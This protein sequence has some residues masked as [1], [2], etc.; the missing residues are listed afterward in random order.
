MRPIA[1]ILLLLATVAAQAQPE[2][3]AATTRAQVDSLLWESGLLR[4]LNAE[5]ARVEIEMLSGASELPGYL[6]GPVYDRIEVL[7]KP[8]QIHDRLTDFMVAHADTDSLARALA[9]VREPLVARV[10]RME[11]EANRA[12]WTDSTAWP[13]F[14]EAWAALAP[15]DRV[16]REALIGRFDDVTQSSVWVRSLEQIIAEA[17]IEGMVLG[18]GAEHEDF[19]ARMYAYRADLPLTPQDEVEVLIR[20]SSAFT[21]QDLS[22]EEV[23]TFTDLMGS[24]I[25]QWNLT[26]RRAALGWAFRE[27][28]LDVGQRAGEAMRTMMGDK[29]GGALGVTDA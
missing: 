10:V 11:Q 26:V 3:S 1:L 15:K 29:P 22:D 24:A 16:R 19:R 25:G 12:S 4:F 21:Y 18:V 23:Q 9:L 27:A 2:P 14:E 17:F 5:I 7:F 20:Q 13:V 6:A 8:A 28:V